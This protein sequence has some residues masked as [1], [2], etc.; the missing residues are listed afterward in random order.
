MWEWHNKLPSEVEEL[1]P[2]FRRRLGWKEKDKQRRGTRV[3]YKPER[4]LIFCLFTAEAPEV[5]RT[6]TLKLT[7]EAKKV[8]FPSGMARL[9]AV[10]A[11]GRDRYIYL[12]S[13]CWYKPILFLEKKG[14]PTKGQT[15]EEG[16]YIEVGIVSVKVWFALS[17]NEC[18]FLRKLL[19][20]RFLSP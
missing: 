11:T 10:E 18:D 20:G 17:S 4:L 8:L 6:R 13:I 15:S 16:K 7:E 3:V 14:D 12:P 9:W 1:A 5:W 19:L 2:E